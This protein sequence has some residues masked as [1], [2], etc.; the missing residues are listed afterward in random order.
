[1]RLL[2]ILLALVIARNLGRPVLQLASY[3]RAIGEGTT[4]E[5][6]AIRAGGEL[7]QLR[8]A[9]RD[10]LSGLRE[11]EAQI[12]YAATHDDVTGLKNR[13]ALMQEAAELFENRGTGSLVGIRLN[14]LSDINDT[15]GL[16]FGDK[17][18]IGMHAD[19]QVRRVDVLPVGG[20]RGEVRLERD[21]DRDRL[22][23]GDFHSGWIINCS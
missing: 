13:N 11:R 19:D 7:T 22:D 23:A 10:M 6:P 20:L 16:E 2:A 8:N 18:L 12:R 1:M 9:L 14:D 17:V 4:P 21:I 5:A 15:L 3:A